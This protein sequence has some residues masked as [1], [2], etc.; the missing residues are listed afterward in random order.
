MPL[1]HIIRLLN[2]CKYN[3]GSEFI[4]ASF[5]F[6]QL[7]GDFEDRCGGEEL[8]AQQKEEIIADALQQLHILHIKHPNLKV[9]VISDST[10]FATRVNQLP[11]VYIIPGEISHI[12][13]K[14][15]ST[16]SF[17]KEFLDLLLLSKAKCIYRYHRAPMHY[18]GFPL[19]AAQIGGI[20]VET[21]EF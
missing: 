9:L 10:V 19:T 14:S 7:L 4:A 5:R 21:I 12:D 15:Q 16:K 3:I 17:D 1:E 6:M 18:S 2:N 11:F 8:S 20:K 13:A